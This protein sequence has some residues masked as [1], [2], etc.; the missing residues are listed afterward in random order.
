[1]HTLFIFKTKLEDCFRSECLLPLPWSCSQHSTAHCRSYCQQTREPVLGQV[2]K[3][4]RSNKKACGTS[5]LWHMFLWVSILFVW[6]NGLWLTK[7]HATAHGFIWLRGILKPEVL[8]MSHPGVFQTGQSYVEFGAAH[9]LLNKSFSQAWI[10]TQGTSRN[11]GA[12]LIHPLRDDATPHA[13]AERTVKSVLHEMFYI[14]NSHRVVDASQVVIL[15][16]LCSSY[17]SLWNLCPSTYLWAAQ[18]TRGPVPPCGHIWTEP[19]PST[20][21]WLRDSVQC[22]ASTFKVDWHLQYTDPQLI[23]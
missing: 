2:A 15:Q 6:W 21:P 7:V 5:W 12:S 17:Y 14:P 9:C 8:G 20:E 18:G 4:G 22:V 19:P 23:F 3:L 13:L 16:S 1:M 10:V 11:L